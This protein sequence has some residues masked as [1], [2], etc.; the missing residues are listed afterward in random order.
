[1]ARRKIG[2]LY[3]WIGWLE[4]MWQHSDMWL[5]QGLLCLSQFEEG[6]N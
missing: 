1:V 4:L 6:F 2:A 5:E 3:L